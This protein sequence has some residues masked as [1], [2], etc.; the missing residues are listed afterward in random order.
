M[1]KIIYGSGGQDGQ[2][3]KKLIPNENF[4]E[5][6]STK[7]ANLI[8]SKNEKLRRDT[9]ESIFADKQIEEIFFL[10]S[11]NSSAIVDNE[12]NT[13]LVLQKNIKLVFDDFLFI[14][15]MVGKYAPEARIFFA[16]SA[17]IFGLPINKPQDET[18][19][20]K[21]VELYGLFKVICHDIINYYRENKNIFISCG[22]LYPHESEFRKQNYLFRKIIDHAALVSRKLNSDP[23][24]IADLQF[25]REW[26][27]AYQ[28]MKCVIEILK[29]ENPVDLVV[30]S[31]IQYSI[32]DFCKL[33]Y[34]YYDLDFRQFVLQQKTEM[35]IRSPN[36]AAQP[37]K[38]IEIIG[39]KPDGDLEALIDRTN[40][41][42]GVRIS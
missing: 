1:P 15:E 37:A 23:L 5:I 30:G 22:I 35:I 18:Q 17:L 40:K 13:S 3:L 21:P 29:H 19:A 7:V 6:S 4:I 41:N 16:S 12:E 10:S 33:A 2:I 20:Y 27:C 24:F 42:L 38:L 32:Q 14:I 8:I 36:L 26:N 25:T 28:I 9:I 31:G 34:G 39:Y 11:I